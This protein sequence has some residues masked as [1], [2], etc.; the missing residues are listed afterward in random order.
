MIVY[1]WRCTHIKSGITRTTWYPTEKE[2]RDSLRAFRKN[3]CGHDGE[4]KCDDCF[5]K[6]SISHKGDLLGLLNSLTQGYEVDQY[7]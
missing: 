5:T 1:W 2:A 6:E 7:V 3:A 4:Y